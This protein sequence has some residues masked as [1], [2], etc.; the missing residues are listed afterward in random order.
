M[1]EERHAEER[2]IV[3]VFFPET[4]WQG[5]LIVQEL[6]GAG[7]EAYLANRSSVAAWSDVMP[8]VK[9]EVVVPEKDAEKARQLI[10]DFFKE[11]GLV[12]ESELEVEAEQASDQVEDK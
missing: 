10:D 7:I 9:L 2:Y 4:E 11:K 6:E 8:L 3:T 1:A 12:P 5:D